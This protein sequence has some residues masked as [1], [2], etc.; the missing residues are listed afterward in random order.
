MSLQYR[1]IN[2]RHCWVLTTPR[3]A[4]IISRAEAER[5]FRQLNAK[6]KEANH[7]H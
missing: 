3:M 2:N 1:N 5:I 7:V 4:A 6:A